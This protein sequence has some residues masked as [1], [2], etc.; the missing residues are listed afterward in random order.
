MTEVA[1]QQSGQFATFGRILADLEPLR[2]DRANLA[3]QSCVFQA[4]HAVGQSLESLGPL[5]RQLELLQGTGD[6]G[7]FG[8][9][10][11]A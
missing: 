5:C 11:Q 8:R 7:L 6:V 2:Q 1:L 9:H 10:G 4:V 3:S